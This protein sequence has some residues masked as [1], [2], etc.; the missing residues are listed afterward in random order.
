[1]DVAISLKTKS[2]IQVALF[3]FNRLFI[4]YVAFERQNRIFL[5]FN[6]K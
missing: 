4:Q 5:Y 3:V 2:A 6:V 1:M